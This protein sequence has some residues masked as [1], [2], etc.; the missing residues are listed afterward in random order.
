MK[1]KEFIYLVWLHSLWFTHKKLHQIFEKTQNYK[2]IFDKIST[3]F[4][5]FLGF[6]NSQI[7]SILSKKD[8][9]NLDFLLKKLEERNVKIITIKDENF[10][11][12][13]KET[14]NCPYF[15]YLRWK[16][17]NS[18]KL[19]IVWSRNITSYWEKAISMI[20]PDLIPYFSIVSGWAA[21]C[22]TFAH[23]ETMKN[24]WTTISVIWT[25]ID[26]DYPATNKKMYDKIV[27]TGWA[28]ISIFPIW[29]IWNAYNFPI[30]NEIVRAMS[31]WVIVIEA[32]EKSWSLI[33][34][35]LALE[36]WKD[37]FAVPGD[38]NKANSRG[39]NNLIKN[40]EAKLVTWSSDILEEYNIL[41]S[42]KIDKKEIEFELEIDKKIYDLLILEWLSIDE[43]C[44]KLKEEI[45]TISFRTSMME[46]EGFIKRWKDWKYMSL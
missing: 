32:K 34:A 28:V 16:I 1:D 33:T 17:D 11:E 10:P 7:E 31:V 26:I 19:A 30:R 14:S 8:K 13:L 36:Q 22:D 6:N 46:L 24:N 23:T 44:E 29:E 25:G 40:S 18:P 2:E 21:W 20:V 4:L 9:I 5:Q 12:I 15:F 3:S 41:F 37:L 35:K 45:T 38:I 43:I 39:C 27:E 42:E